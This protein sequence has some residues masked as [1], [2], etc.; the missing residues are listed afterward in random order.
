MDCD[1]NILYNCMLDMI[2]AARAEFFFSLPLKQNIKMDS[3]AQMQAEYQAQK[4][5]R[6]IEN[7]APYK[8]TSQR[9]RLVGYTHRAT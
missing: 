3:I 5:T 6:T 9:L 7:I 1:P 4:M 2:N 8:Y